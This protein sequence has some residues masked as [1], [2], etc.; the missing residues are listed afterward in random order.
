[1]MLGP[2]VLGAAIIGTGVLIFNLIGNLSKLHDANLKLANA[3]VE[4]SFQVEQSIAVLAEE[5]VAVDR[6]TLAGKTKA[7][8]LAILEKKMWKVVDAQDASAGAATKETAA[9]KI[10]G[11]ANLIA[12]GQVGQL[13]TAEEWAARALGT[14]TGSLEETKTATDL[15]REALL[16]AQGPQ[17]DSIWAF[18]GIGASADGAADAVKRLIDELN[19]I[20][21]AQGGAGLGF[22]AGGVIPGF[23]AGGLIPKFAG[24]G[25][26]GLGARIVKVGEKGPELAALPIGTHILSNAESKQAVREGVAGARTQNMTFTFGDII[27]QDS[28]DPQQTAREI[29]DL[30]EVEMADRLEDARVTF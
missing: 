23:A 25:M 30:I 10:S 13:A 5:G 12:S 22:A 6:S 21:S 27:V 1:T 4:L 17:S 16:S 20:P 15:Y 18:R 3:E 24:G 11:E 8:Q 7:Q 14:T 2:V 19:S 28:S 9:T 26:V 29:V